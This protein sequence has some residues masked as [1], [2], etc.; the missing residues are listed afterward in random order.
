MQNSYYFSRYNHIWGWATWKRAWKLNDNEMSGWPIFRDS[1]LLSE[2]LSG[3]REASYWT[4]VLNKVYAGDID[5]WDCRWTLSCW[6]NRLLTVIP[7]VN[8]ISNIG[9]GPDATHTPVP[10]RYAAMSTESMVFP[11]MHPSKIE[12]DSDADSYTGK[13]MYRNYP[14]ISRFIALMRGMLR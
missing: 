3:K 1:G 10:N 4:E 11:L 13:T 5:T 6:S 8:L 7:A 2:M 14:V 9:F 12:A